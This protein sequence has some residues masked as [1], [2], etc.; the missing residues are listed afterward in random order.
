MWGLHTPGGA[1]FHQFLDPSLQHI[2][3]VVDNVIY[4]QYLLLQI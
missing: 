2:L 4:I 1:P 3:D